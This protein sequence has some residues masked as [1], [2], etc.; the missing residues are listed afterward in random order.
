[1]SFL[2]PWLWYLLS[3]LAMCVLFSGLEK[4]NGKLGFTAKTILCLWVTISSVITVALFGIQGFIDI[5]GRLPPL[6]ASGIVLGASCLTLSLSSC[7]VYCA[8]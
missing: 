2:K 7:C 3:A 8:I 5:T 6:Q 1:M 4:A